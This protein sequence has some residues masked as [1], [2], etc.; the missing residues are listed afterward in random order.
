MKI[1]KNVI[2]AEFIDLVLFMF[3]FV[4][5]FV[6]MNSFYSMFFIALTI[7]I[8]LFFSWSKI[9]RSWFN[10]FNIL[11]IL[12]F[13]Y[14]FG[15]YLL[16]VLGFPLSYQY[17]IKNV[18]T[19]EQINYAASFLL[20]NM[21][22]LHAATIFFYKNKMYTCRKK[23]KRNIYD[24]RSFEI[25]SLIM[26]F[27]SFICKI[28]VL[29]Y[30][31]KINFT[32]GY[33]AMMSAKWGNG[34]F[35]TIVNFCATFYLPAL[36]ACLVATKDKKIKNR[37]V[38]ISYCI[39]I[40]LYFLSGSRFDAIVSITG[41]VLLY[42]NFY[43]KLELKKVL[44]IGCMGIGFLFVCSVISN[45]RIVWGYGQTT[46]YLAIFQEALELSKDGNLL[47]DTISVAGFQI[48]SV[49]TVMLKCPSS[50]PY[51]YGVYYLMG[52]ARVIPN[53]TGGDNALITESIDEIFHVFLTKTYGMGSSFIIEAYYNFGYL[54]FL[55]MI[56]YGFFI[57]YA[58]KQ[59]EN[60]RKNENLQMVSFIFYITSASF[61]WIRSDARML[62]R[63]IVYYYFGFKFITF[64][65]KNILYRKGK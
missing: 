1:Q 57:A 59:I 63:E 19:P 35:S 28:I 51:S 12:S 2:I 42:H 14:Y 32:L 24:K 49:V 52:I 31:C 64:I 29:I 38:W 18:Y 53:I 54:G 25:A 13:I 11:I 34:V 58:V 40:C 7:H 60:I 45:I 6:G 23:Q 26:L 48:L 65:I 39:F 43:K 8:Y 22:V 56:A 5:M 4:L 41:I 21:I 9:N 46:N 30:K 47:S 62:I 16:L 27:V 44:F 20:L 61:F 36:F 55:M 17:T 10:Y 37:V 33:N 3:T 50:I 15:Q